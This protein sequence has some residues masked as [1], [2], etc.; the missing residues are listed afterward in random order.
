M[1]YEELLIEL[2]LK[3][4]I[5]DGY[6]L[7]DGI[8]EI[9]QLLKIEPVLVRFKEAESFADD[10]TWI[11]ANPASRILD[12]KKDN[13]DFS[14]FPTPRAIYEIARELF[15]IR[16]A[17]K[18]EDENDIDAMA[19]GLDCM[20]MFF[21]GGEEVEIVY[22]IFTAVKNSLPLED[23]RELLKRYNELK[24]LFSFDDP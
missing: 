15:R 5:W 19:F 18:G 17:D 13:C 11:E 22:P 4:P 14:I 9:C 8:K 2:C 1:N 6:E 20:D 21:D 10:Q 12:I 7:Q 23:R 16:Q 24:P 3:N